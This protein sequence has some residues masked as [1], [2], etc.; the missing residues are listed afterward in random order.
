MRANATAPEN[1]DN[2]LNERDFGVFVVVMAR[3][4]D[5]REAYK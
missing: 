5:L 2:V 3:I 4:V 1:M